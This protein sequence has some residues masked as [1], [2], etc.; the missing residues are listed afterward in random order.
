MRTFASTFGIGNELSCVKRFTGVYNSLSCHLDCGADYRSRT[1]EWHLPSAAVR[2]VDEEEV[3][4][5][6]RCGEWLILVLSPEPLHDFVDVDSL[7][8]GCRTCVDI[9]WRA[10]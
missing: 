9:R 8:H 5:N 7:R 1:L 6:L 3:Q 4:R 10:P 2:P